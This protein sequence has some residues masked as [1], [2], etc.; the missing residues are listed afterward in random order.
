MLLAIDIGNTNVTIGLFLENNLK[1][2]LRINSHPVRAA[3]FY[4]RRIESFLAQ[5]NIV[6]DKIDGIVIGSVVPRLIEPFK[7]M[8]HTFFHLEPLFVNCNLN[9]G[10]RLLV[11]N[12]AEVGADRICNAVA[13]GINYPCPSI[14]VDLGTATTFDVLDREGNYIGGAIAPGLVTGASD[15]FRKAAQLYR[16]NLTFPPQVIG[17]NTTAHMQSGILFGHLSMIEGMVRRIAEEIHQPD[18]FVIATGGFSNVVA[19]HSNVIKVSDPNLTLDGL[20]L[21]YEMNQNTVAESRP[22]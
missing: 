9:L 3:D 17:K 10:R 11:D 15:L 4:N 6:I 13:A 19:Q 5:Q 1:G 2:F 14:V 8:A 12:P 16:I 18:I 7:Q 22:V 21:I 20:R